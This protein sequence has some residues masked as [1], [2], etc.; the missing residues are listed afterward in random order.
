MTDVDPNDYID[1][2]LVK[3]QPAVFEETSL[4]LDDFDADEHM[5]ILSLQSGEGGIQVEFTSR[6]EQKNS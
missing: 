5:V 2:S 6:Q 3:V 4:S 1:V